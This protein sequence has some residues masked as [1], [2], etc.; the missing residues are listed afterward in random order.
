MI[1]TQKLAELRRDL[2]HL[3][4][5]NE[6]AEQLFETLEALWKVMEAAKNLNQHEPKIAS[7]C[8][9]AQALAA[10]EDKP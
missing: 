6:E 7:I 1:D 10:L 5:S 3:G 9:I 2:P 8:G 4:C